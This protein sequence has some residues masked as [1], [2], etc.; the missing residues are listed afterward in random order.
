MLGGKIAIR[1]WRWHTLKSAGG[2]EL[3]TIGDEKY[4][5]GGLQHGVRQLHLSAVADRALDKRIAIFGNHRRQRCLKIYALSW[6]AHVAVKLAQRTDEAR[7]VQA[8]AKHRALQR[9]HHRQRAMA[10]KG[11]QMSTLMQTA[12]AFRERGHLSRALSA[13]CRVYCCRHQISR[14]LMLRPWKAWKAY[15]AIRRG[16]HVRIC[17]G[18][19]GRC[20]A[21]MRKGFR[22]L[23]EQA[24]LARAS[25]SALT[26]AGEHCT[27]ARKRVGLRVIAQAAAARRWQVLA[28]DSYRIAVVAHQVILRMHRLAR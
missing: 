2:R 11:T 14:V 7:R 6:R 15:L 22:G 5:L 1:R 24:G 27:R 10:T 8:A 18:T 25:Q 28:Q 26:A 16:K 20:R 21:L 12:Q 19:R 3:A 9:W 4:R 13:F 17:E 23:V